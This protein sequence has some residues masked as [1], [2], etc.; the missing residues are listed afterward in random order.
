[1]RRVIAK[2]LDEAL[3]VLDGAGI[4]PAKFRGVPLRVMSFIMKL[5]TPVVRLV[6]RAQLRVDPEARVSMWTD[7]ERGRPTEVDVLNGEIVRVAG[8]HGGAAP[9]N[10]RIAELVHEAER[11]GAGSPNMSPETLLRALEDD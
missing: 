1:Y 10:R 9:I 8:E 3:D 11:A 4:R 2:L 7:L 5:P 6:I